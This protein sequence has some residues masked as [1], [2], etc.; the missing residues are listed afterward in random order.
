MTRKKRQLL[1][2]LLWR[3][4]KFG[5]RI[6]PFILFRER[7]SDVPHHSWPEEYAAYRVIWLTAKDMLAVSALDYSF[8]VPVLHQK[9]RAGHQCLGLIHGQHIIAVSWSDPAQCNHKPYI[10]P[11]FAN[12]A[13][14]YG[15][16][17]LPAYRGRGLAQYL[18]YMTYRNLAD[19]GK[20][21]FYSVTDYFNKPSIKFKEKLHARRLKLCVAISIGKWLR[22][23]FVLKDY[24][25]DFHR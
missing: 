25:P 15:A 2:G 24:C 10:F 20:D 21:T 22:R 6:E 7:L 1:H 4:A 23:T 11:L 3:L 8:P 17:V 13:Y 18:R 9:L 12:E 5:I 19:E 16:S 14:L